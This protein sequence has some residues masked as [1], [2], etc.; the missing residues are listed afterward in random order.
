MY[1]KFGPEVFECI[2]RNY[3]LLVQRMK[4]KGDHRPRKSDQY[5]LVVELLI[6]HKAETDTETKS[7]VTVGFTTKVDRQTTSKIWV[8]SDRL[9]TRSK[10]NRKDCRYLDRK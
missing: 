4:K 5:E 10:S 1:V 3:G 8:T 6:M 7:V 2:N 9:C